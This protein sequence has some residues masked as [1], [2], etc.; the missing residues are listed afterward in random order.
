MP[1]DGA[2]HDDPLV[3]LSQ[4]LPPQN[5]EAEQALLG[6][7][8]ANNTAFHRVC[9]VLRPEHFADPANGRIYQ[10]AGRLILRGGVADAVSLHSVFEQAG[11]LDE[12]GGTPYLARLL[13]TMVG[14][15]PAVEYARAVYSCYQRRQ[16]IEW[17]ETVIN[18]AFGGE[19]GENADGEAQIA[20]ATD[21]LMDLSAAATSD[22]PAISIGEAARRALRQAEAE[23]RGE[24][25]G[26][27][28]SGFNSFDNAVGALRPGWFYI[29]GGRPSHGKSSL[30]LQ[31]AIGV[32]RALRIEAENAPPFSG[33]GGQVLFFSLEMPAD[34]VGGWAACQLAGVPND[35]LNGER[36]TTA[37]EAEAILHAQRD[38]DGLPLQIIDAV[39]MSG[40]AMALRTRV[41]GQ[42]VAV[43]LVIVDHL[44]KVVAGLEDKRFG[45]FNPTLE[46]GRTTSA[47][48]DL[49][50]QIAAPVMVLAQ[51]RA[52]VDH[53]ENPRPRLADLLYAGG[54]DADVAMFLF[55]EERY[56]SRQP[57]DKLPKETDEQ[58]SK[59]R[60][61]WHRK[62][63][64]C[65]NR[66]ELLVEKRRQGP[67]GTVSLGFNA[68][69][70]SFYDVGTAGPD[71]QWEAPP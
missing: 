11:V 18:R 48:K 21:G 13:A 54:A 26:A 65:R 70:T 40:P 31:V 71:D 66:A 30:A 58:Y 6:A 19:L 2:L 38:L 3:G 22:Q 61:T 51:L 10:E 28:R 37:A 50:R 63:E 56:L 41:E 24:G 53:R 47:L 33:A 42:R 8:L 1:R 44:Q 57:P 49:S 9:G 52:D 35:V 64:A 43:R 4:R 68:Q 36:P 20:A 55:R 45:A 29:L 39:G 60:D 62:W 16:L 25:I 46:T 5:L 7:I 27:L 59:R 67:L 32:A 14:I 69:C 15:Q 12:V 17:G 23:A 34:Q